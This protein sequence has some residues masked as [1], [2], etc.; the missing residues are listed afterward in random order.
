MPFFILLLDYPPFN[1]KIVHPNLGGL[2]SCHLLFFPFQ[3]SY[4]TTW[5]VLNQGPQG[6]ET[7][8][9][10]VKEWKLLDAKQA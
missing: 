7:H 5:S 8:C 6:T 2:K 10:K 4:K 3:R 9:V 1:L